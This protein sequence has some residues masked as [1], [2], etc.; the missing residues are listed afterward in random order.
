MPPAPKV[1]TRAEGTSSYRAEAIPVVHGLTFVS[2][3]E[4]GGGYEV[5]AWLEQAWRLYDYDANMV[6]AVRKARKIA[7]RLRKQGH[8]DRG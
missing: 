8:K 2:P 4:G 5:Y 1:P 6:D 3:M 7:F